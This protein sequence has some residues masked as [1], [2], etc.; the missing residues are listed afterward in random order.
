MRRR[1]EREMENEAMNIKVHEDEGRGGKIL[2]LW[3][4][5]VQATC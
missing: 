1:G 3:I 4:S 5:N 2:V